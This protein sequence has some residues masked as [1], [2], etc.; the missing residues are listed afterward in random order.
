[1]LGMPSPATDASTV[2]EVGSP[3]FQRAKQRAHAASGRA[4]LGLKLLQR[5]LLTA[6]RTRSAEAG[7]CENSFSTESMNGTVFLM[8]SVWNELTAV[9]QGVE[10][11]PQLWRPLVPGSELLRESLEA[12]LRRVGWGSR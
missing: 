11:R 2:C 7:V 1:M 3:V 4:L 6:S 10:R 8:I 5:A 9:Q 12:L